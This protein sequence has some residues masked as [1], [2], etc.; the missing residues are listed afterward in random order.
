MCGLKEDCFLAW[1]N[2]GFSIYKGN[3][4]FLKVLILLMTITIESEP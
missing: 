1:S 3:N 2:K 4:D